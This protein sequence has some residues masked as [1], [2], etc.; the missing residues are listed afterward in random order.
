MLTL[1]GLLLGIGLILSV[2]AIFVSVMHGIERREK[3]ELE[4]IIGGQ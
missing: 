1:L 3:A 4:Q 2:I